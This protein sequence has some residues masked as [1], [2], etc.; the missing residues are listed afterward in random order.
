MN[1]IP[2]AVLLLGLGPLSVFLFT[3]F[4]LH[5]L[6]FLSPGREFVA[7]FTLALA[8][9]VYG[10]WE[11]WDLFYPLE[12]I[13]TPSTLYL[14]LVALCYVLAIVAGLVGYAISRILDLRPWLA[15][16]AYVAALILWRFG[17]TPTLFRTRVGRPLVSLEFARQAARRKMRPGER[18]IEWGT[19]PLH[20]NAAYRHFLVVGATGG[21][22]TI[23]QRLLMQQVLPDIGR[24]LDCRA[25]I[26]DGKGDAFSDLM[27][28]G[29]ATKP[30][31]LNPHDR[32]C[33]GW[34][35]AQDLKL[36]ETAAI[37]LLF[38][39]KVQEAQ[40]HFRNAT[41][42]L[43]RNILTAFRTSCSARGT[44]WNLRDVVLAFEDESDL[45]EILQLVPAV[46]RSTKRY[47][48]ARSLD[49]VLSEAANILGECESIA[50]VWDKARL[51]SLN[52]WPFEES[53][54]LLA[55]HDKDRPAIDMINRLVIRRL[56]EYVLTDPNAKR[57]T[58]TRRTWFFLDEFPSLG[59]VEG[60]QSLLTKGRS[61]RVCVFLGFQDI[62]E[63]EN[64]YGKLAITMANQC[65]TRAIFG[66]EHQA[67][68]W[69]AGFFSNFERQGK[70][71][72]V[73]EP[74]EIMA[75]P[76]PSMENGLQGFYA[77]AF[78]D[79]PYRA[80]ISGPDLF[81]P[82]G[83]LKESKDNV[84]DFEPRPDEDFVL[85]PWDDEDRKRLGLKPKRGGKD[86]LWDLPGVGD[87]ED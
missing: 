36:S 27:G 24:G 79:N 19:V 17:L 86:P 77:S 21:G 22:K 12:D 16:F 3:F 83:L 61:Y 39:P 52:N 7:A 41:R 4:V 64:E 31:I 10:F 23:T 75:L 15:L 2:A 40:P 54:L 46:W 13:V 47:L 14:P 58:P 30:I 28:M 48:K 74:A 78:L 45:T 51:I 68:E 63:V 56:S 73:V 5:D 57:R 29:L 71:R 26:Y 87:D 44:T 25:V 35:I 53:I 59:R 9:L 6:R 50:A 67:A 62:S 65:R 1:K 20:I 72:A 70:W 43:F 82:G 60:I 85:R 38:V 11:V 34:D 76:P 18:Y 84:E 81:G 8:A 42:I 69:A 32:R 37:A 55:A 49:E 80:N 66:L 33:V